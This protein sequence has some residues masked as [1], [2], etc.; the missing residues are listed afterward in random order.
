MHNLALIRSK[1]YFFDSISRSISL[2]Q[3][4]E[5][6][7]AMTQNKTVSAKPGS[8]SFVTL[9]AGAAALGG[10]LFGFDTAVING[11]VSAIQNHFNANSLVTG[12]SVSLALLGSAIGA[13]SAGQ[14]ADRIGRTRTMLIAATIFVISAIGSGLPFTIWDFMFWRIL[15]GTGVGAASVIAPA[16][17]AEVSPAHLRGRLGSLQQLAIVLGIFIALLSNYFIATA[18]GGSAEN[19]WLFN[20][21]A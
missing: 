9:I 7:I 20:F 3:L 11:A 13:F 15:G 10:F 8:T 18:A 1:K 17:I 14:I 19:A 6:I 4:R 5:K 21:E 16:Y 12:L 2:L